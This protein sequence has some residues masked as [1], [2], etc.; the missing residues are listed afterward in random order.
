MYKEGLALNKLQ[1][2]ICHKTQTNH[3]TVDTITILECKQ[4]SFNSIKKWNYWQTMCKQITD[5]ELRLLHKN[6]WKH[7]I[8]CKNMN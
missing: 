1:W 4:I 3:L 2:L 5:V 8:V 7:S 6:P